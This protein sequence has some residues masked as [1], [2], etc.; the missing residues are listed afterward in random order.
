VFL[1]NA[2]GRLGAARASLTGGILM[3]GRRPWLA[4]RFGAVF[5]RV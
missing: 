1:R 2:Y 4:R 3:W 5:V